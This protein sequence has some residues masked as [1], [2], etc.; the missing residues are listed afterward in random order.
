VQKDAA[1][2]FRLDDGAVDVIGQVRVRS[3]HH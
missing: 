2:D 3:K 1:F